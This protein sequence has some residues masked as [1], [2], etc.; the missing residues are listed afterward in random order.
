MNDLRVVIFDCD[1]VMFDTVR[2]NTAYYN[3]VLEHFEKPPMTPAQ[4]EFVHMHTADES[5][6]CL[7][8]D[9]QDFEQAQKFREKM[10]YMP[11]IRHMVIEPDLTSLLKTIRPRVK[12]A[13]ATNRSDTMSRVLKEFSLEGLFDLVV[14]SRDV[15]RPKPFPD[16]LDKVIRGLEIRP[17][18]AIYVGDSKVD[19]AAAQAAQVPLAAYRNPSLMARWHIERLK[20]IENIIESF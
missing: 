18:Q 19:E 10:T 17:G 3:S 16:V 13:V 8:P 6:A 5:I 11:F 4:F 14:T 9:K 12:T 20:E 1:G 15:E 7:F 2:A